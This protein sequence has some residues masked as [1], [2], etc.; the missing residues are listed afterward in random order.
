MNVITRGD[1]KRLPC[2]SCQSLASLSSACGLMAVSY[3]EISGYCASCS[4]SRW[5]RERS[6]RNRGCGECQLWHWQRRRKVV[7]FSRS[8]NARHSGQSAHHL[9]VGLFLSAHPSPVHTSELHSQL[10]E[11][12][13]LTVTFPVYINFFLQVFKS[14]PLLLAF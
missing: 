3:P 12:F 5:S 4:D 6:V 1:V 8:I 7:S 9:C 2:F 14:G 11:A 13:T 10:R